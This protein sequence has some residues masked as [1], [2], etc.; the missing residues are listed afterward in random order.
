MLLFSTVLLLG[1][2]VLVN[3]GFSAETV[4]TCLENMPHR[5]SC[6]NFGVISVQTSL[7]GRVDS[8][9]CSDGQ[10]SVTDCSLPGAVDIV[11]KRCNG[12][13]VCELSSNVFTS[14]PCWGTA[15]HLQTTYTCLPAITSVTCEHSLTHLK[16][17][18]GQIISV[19]SA[20]YGRRDLTTC[21]YGRPISQ[22]Q[23]SAC[24]NPTNKVA[25]SCE[26]KNSCTIQA[27]NSVFGDPCVGTNKYLEVAYA[28]QYPS[29]SQ[30]KAV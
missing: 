28:C 19:Y 29:N 5:L 22:I 30:G 11:K 20:D 2:S 13:R 9:V 12:K 24:F 6:E 26:G 23:N 16:C 3:A 14:D 1:T 15:K 4:T 7:Y 17:D 21:I 8:S 27:S 18:E 10:A 25:D